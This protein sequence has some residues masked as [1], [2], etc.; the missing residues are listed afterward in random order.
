MKCAPLSVD[1]MPS[2]SSLDPGLMRLHGVAILHAHSRVSI[3]GS[4]FPQAP[5][6]ALTPTIRSAMSPYW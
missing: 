6:Q 4:T 5:L 3:A 1:A 2:K